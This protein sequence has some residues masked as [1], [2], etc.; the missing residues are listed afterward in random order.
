MKA[1]ALTLALILPGV[2]GA[3]T[4]DTGTADN[5]YLTGAEIEVS[6]ASPADLLAAAGTV[7]VSAPVTGD[8]LLAGG[9]VNLSA[10]VGGDVRAAGGR[11]LISGTAAGDMVLAGGTVI[12]TGKGKE[13]RVAG[14]AVELRGGAEGPVTVYGGTVYLS[15]EF[16]GDVSVVASDHVTLGDHTLIH[17]AFEYNAPQEA[18]IPASAVIDDGVEYTGSASFLP[19]K[20]EADTFALAGIGVFFVVRLL[21]GALAAGLLAGLFPGFVRSAT[22]DAVM[23]SPKRFFLRAL[24]GGAVLLLTPLV[25]LFLL[26]S[27]VGIGIAALVGSAY[28]LALLLSYLLAAVFA[29]ALLMRL[30]AKRWTV[31]WKTA[32]LG[33][34]LLYILGLVPVLGFVTSSLFSLAALG[35]L[36]VVCHRF[37]FRRG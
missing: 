26:A 17:G 16:L 31:S 37:A 36:S 9:T 25:L 35:T 32:L 23:H 8:V 12:V 20:K 15:G 5:A 1:L 34:A 28:L 22:E 13:M 7:I 4:T 10:P 6:T 24:L 21:A 29:G 14:G 19:T 18:E 33:M 30:F 2:V 27:F 3:T 11:V